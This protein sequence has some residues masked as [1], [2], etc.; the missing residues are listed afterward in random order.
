MY[1]RN[2]ITQPEGLLKMFIIEYTKQCWVFLNLLF[3]FWS[4]P[5]DEEDHL[6]HLL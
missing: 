1:G 6:N 4:D 5:K 3:V 2:T